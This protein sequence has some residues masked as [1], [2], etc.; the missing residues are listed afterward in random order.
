MIKTEYREGIGRN[1]HEYYSL[2]HFRLKN[3][4]MYFPDKG[5]VEGPKLEG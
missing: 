3:Y 4:G 2:Y 5:P 1:N